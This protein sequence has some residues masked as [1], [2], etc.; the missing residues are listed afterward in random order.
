MKVVVL[1]LDAVG[2]R[3]A[4][5]AIRSVAIARELAPHADVVLAAARRSG[6]LD[7]GI[8]IVAYDRHHGRKMLS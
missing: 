4:G 2:P 8:P 1:C 5:I 6:D 3:M 7:L